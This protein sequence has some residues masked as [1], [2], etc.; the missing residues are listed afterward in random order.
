M[1]RYKWDPY[2]CEQGIVPNSARTCE[3]FFYVRFHTRRRPGRMLGNVYLPASL[4]TV[5]GISALY[6]ND[7]T[8][9]DTTDPLALQ[10]TAVLTIVALKL[11]FE[12]MLP[13]GVGLT[14]LDKYLMAS[15]VL[16]VSSILILTY[17]HTDVLNSYGISFIYL[18]IW[19]LIQ[20][21]FFI[22]GF[23]AYRLETAKEGDKV[24]SKPHVKDGVDEC[25]GKEMVKLEYSFGVSNFQRNR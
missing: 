4:V 1:S 5:M 21:V 22:T 19:F 11:V 15:L 14:L 18:G 23:M 13:K 9:F 17:V 8:A 24:N 10:S 7:Q 20:L 3:S 16:V 25:R 6:V 2:A 12:D